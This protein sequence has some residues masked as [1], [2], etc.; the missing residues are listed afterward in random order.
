[1]LT[2][3]YSTLS[4]TIYVLMDFKN[5]LCLRKHGN[6]QLCFFSYD[7]VELVLHQTQCNFSNGD[8]AATAHFSAWASASPT[9]YLPYEISRIPA[10]VAN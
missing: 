1:M 7:L 3:T 9:A 10:S 6:I 2:I 5:L 8:L 4:M